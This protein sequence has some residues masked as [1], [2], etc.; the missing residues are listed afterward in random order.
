MTAADPP[1]RLPRRFLGQGVSVRLA[2]SFLSIPNRTRSIR[3]R[4]DRLKST[5]SRQSLAFLGLPSRKRRGPLKASACAP[6]AARTNSRRSSIGDDSQPADVT[7]ER[8]IPRAIPRWGASF[9]QRGE[10]E[11]RRALLWQELWA[12]RGG[13]CGTIRQVLWDS[14]AGVLDL[15]HGTAGTR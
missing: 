5:R 4:S 2:E 14:L 15:R 6:E 8:E 13:D 12:D 11:R 3:T 7:S 9:S 1:G 10:A